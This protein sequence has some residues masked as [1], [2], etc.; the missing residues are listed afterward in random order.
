ME[1]YLISLM[2]KRLQH[3]LE[4]IMN[5]KFGLELAII[6]VLI[7]ANG[8]FAM[9]EMA[10]VSARKSRLRR[11]ARDGVKGAQT[12]L[13]LAASP[14]RFLSTVQFGITLIGI[15]AGAFGG[16]TIATTVSSWVEQSPKLAPHA[17]KI[18]FGIVVVFI[19]LASLIFGE[20]LPKRLALAQGE[21]IA[22]TLA[23]MMHGLSIVASPFVSFVGWVIEMTLK[24]LGV[25]T[26]QDSSVSEEDIRVMVEQGSHAGTFHKAEIELVAS[27][28]RL[29]ETRIIDIMLPFAQMV[30]LDTSDRGQVLNEKIAKAG[31]SYFPLRDASNGQILGLISL[32]D[33]WTRYSGAA[34][35][36]I[37]LKALVSTPL[38][39]PESTHVVKLLEAF[40]RSVWHAALVADE[41]G[42]ITG[43]VSVLDVMEAI[44]GDFSHLQD[45]TFKRPRQLPDGAWLADGLTDVEDVVRAISPDRPLPIPPGKYHTLG[46]MVVTVL[47]RIP[48]EGDRIPWEDYWIEVV[49]MDRNRVDKL[50]IVKGSVASSESGEA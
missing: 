5:G 33:L 45:E 22:S 8:L 50:R 10:I 29:D 48:E 43:M 42:E 39:V 44:A 47:G 9:A 41:Y 40:K 30:C 1:G 27:V 2:T 26:H 15:L 49:D 35:E 38:L 11:W 25:R 28:M 4:D 24:I 18:G 37:D 3:G 13:D 36:E 16:A 23:P 17:D 32:R 21:R 31:R 6:C 7:L 12:A 14:N 34:T 20:I 46:G 19:T